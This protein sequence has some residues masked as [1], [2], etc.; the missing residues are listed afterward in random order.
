ML[1]DFAQLFNVNVLHLLDKSFD[2]LGAVL[3]EHIGLTVAL[4][5]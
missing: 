3:V 4:I 5:D 2:D 1:L